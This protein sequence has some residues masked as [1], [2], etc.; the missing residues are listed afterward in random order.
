LSDFENP[1]NKTARTAQTN[2]IPFV[3]PELNPACTVHKKDIGIFNQPE[4]TGTSTQCGSH[5][6]KMQIA[7]KMAMSLS[8]KLRF[9][10][11]SG[12]V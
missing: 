11:D 9:I 3:F 1:I 6:N 8:A 10:V 7:I 2:L 5:L 12:R 4:P